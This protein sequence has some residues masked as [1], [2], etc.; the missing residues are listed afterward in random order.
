M[1]EARP[2]SEMIKHNKG[3]SARSSDQSPLGR[4]NPLGTKESLHVGGSPFG[5]KESL[6]GEG[7]PSGQQCSSEVIVN[8]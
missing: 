6:Q 5:T 1:T 3:H 4:T 7:V 2:S 8:E